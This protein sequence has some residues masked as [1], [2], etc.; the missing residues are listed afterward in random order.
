VFPPSFYLSGPPSWWSTS[1]PFPAIG[2][3]VNGGN[4]GI[5]SG[6][7]NTAGHYS[8]VAAL[9][10]SQ[11]SPG[12]ALTASQW[13]GHV[14]AIPALA[15]YLNVMNGPPDGSGKALTFSAASCYGSGGGG[16]PQAPTGL[17]AVVH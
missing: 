6:T 5:C 3:D 17:T 2:P 12:P 14:N 13:G 10:S 9:T 7:L 15:C 4:L 8:G 11:C 16:A 1:I